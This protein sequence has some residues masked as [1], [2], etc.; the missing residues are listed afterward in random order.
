MYSRKP[1]PKT[2]HEILRG[3]KTNEYTRA[4]DTRRDND[5]IKDI[6]V[7]LF[8][9]DN[10]IK[11]YFDNVIK[12]RVQDFENVLE[13]PVIY[14]SPEKWKSM[15]ADGYFRDKL[16]KIQTPLIAYRRTGITKNRALGTK[17]DANAP[18]LY[19]SSV[20]QYTRED[21]YDQFSVL[22]NSK[23]IKTI[24]N[25]VIPDYVDI[26][27]D[28]V[29]WTDFIE[30]MNKLVEAIIYTEGSFW[31]EPN[32]FNFRT[33]IDNFTNTTDLLQDSDRVIRTSFSLTIFGYIIP[34]VLAKELSNK[35]APKNFSNRQ[36]LVETDTDSQ[37]S[38]VNPPTPEPER[39]PVVMQ[40]P[41]TGSL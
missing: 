7:G 14:G 41:I 8:D 31:G 1:L 22:T 23:P 13:V 28:I 16:G 19:Q 34:D 32:R 12:P 9:I 2:D 6:T 15:Q 40:G 33:K 37:E 29:I 35:L 30:H 27:Y 24:I 17:V 21:Q 36:I 25:T 4:N 11:W 3:R 39:I 18:A 5:K 38:I 26:T 20:Q 10:A